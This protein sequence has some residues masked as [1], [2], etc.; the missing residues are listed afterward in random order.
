LNAPDQ[1]PGL[2]LDWW[3]RVR[4][5]LR[6]AIAPVRMATQLLRGGRIDA[7]ER[8]E[9]LQVIDRQL[10][11]LLATAE[12]IGDLLQAQA[13][14]LALQAEAQDANL[15]LDV[16]CGRGA[17]V[18]ELG[19]RKL[20]LR[21]E[22]CAQELP[23]VHDATRVAALLEFLLLR[24]AA[25]TPAGGEL[26]LGL[27]PEEGGVLRLSG[28]GS[29]LAQ[30]P[31]LLFLQGIDGGNGEPGLR[32]LMLRELLR[33]SGMQLRAAGEGALELRFARAA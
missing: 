4:H 16:V 28:A 29:G 22:P 10:E 30:N 14:R 25:H 17:L 6:S 13:G 20:Q 2:P 11:Q 12:D 33:A 5:D 21:C 7:N 24:M 31:E 8:E 26:V 9:A 18:R 3:R 23:V 27:R 19:T 15:L 1:E 32:A